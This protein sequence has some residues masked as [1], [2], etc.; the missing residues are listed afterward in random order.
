MEK[1]KVKKKGKGKVIKWIIIILILVAAIGCGVAACMNGISGA[2]ETPAAPL[3]GEEFGAHDMSTYISTNGPV[4][5]KNIDVVTTNLPYPI[6][7]VNV[8]IGDSVKKGDVICEIDTAEIDK[9]ISKLEEQATDSDRLQ[10]KQIEMANHSVASA[11]K[12]QNASIASAAKAVENTRKAYETAVSGREALET[13]LEIAEEEYE[14]AEDAYEAAVEA[15]KAA[16]EYVEPNTEAP[17]PIV[18]EAT[19]TD[20]AQLQPQT[21]PSSS[22]PAEPDTTQLDVEVIKA[23]ERLEECGKTVAEYSGKLSQIDELKATYDKAVDAYNELIS[24]GN[25]GVQSAQ[26]QADLQQIQATAYS[27]QAQLLASAYEEKKK[28]VIIA[29]QEGLVTSI[30]AVEGIPA[31]QGNLM[32]IEDDKNLRIEVLIKERDILTVKEGQ[33]VI[34]SSE[35]IDS[36]HAKGVVS[37]VYRFNANKEA[38]GDMSAMTATDSNMYKAIVDV[39]EN[40]GLMLGMNAKVDVVVEDIG[41]KMCVAYTAI[42][43]YSGQDYVY[44]ARPSAQS[45]GLYDLV[46]TPV[47]TGQTGGYYTEILSGLEVGDIVINTPDEVIEGTPANVSIKMNKDER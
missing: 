26:D 20:P 29:D 1:K 16:G 27:E 6:K 47:T 4:I 34:I 21:D 8:E 14:A 41:E 32:Q 17:N 11:A 22:K 2:L 7:S 30:K 18:P 3:T 15:A 42:K 10:A 37:K 39:T 33:E 46:K 25:D 43:N 40:G 13:I 38:M 45:A 9:N 28:T 35:N 44:V 24:A 23:K 31:Q 12:S 36:I 19:P 5:S